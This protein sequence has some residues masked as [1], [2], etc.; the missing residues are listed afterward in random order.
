MT[1][2]HLQGGGGPP[3]IPAATFSNPAFQA[4]MAGLTPSQQAQVLFFSISL[5]TSLSHKTCFQ[6]IA[7]AQQQALLANGGRPAGQQQPN[8][9]A[10]Q[11]HQSSQQ[12]VFG[13][14]PAQQQGLGG[15]VPGQQSLEA[16]SVGQPGLGA[17]QARQPGGP[18]GLGHQFPNQLSGPYRGHIQVWLVLI[19][20]IMNLCVGHWSKPSLLQITCIFTHFQTKAP[21]QPAPFTQQSATG[22]VGPTSENRDAR[23]LQ[24]SRSAQD[25]RQQQ[26]PRQHPGDM[27]HTKPFASQPASKVLIR[28]IFSTCWQEYHDECQST[29]LFAKF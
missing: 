10:P 17:N 20:A 25:S 1:R 16:D 21:A 22:P 6:V 2:E 26:D 15:A 5:Y 23:G 13:G 7:N 11:H 4:Q 8:P 27:Q 18:T 14:L 19:N 24:D 12:Q 9:S 28:I 29:L 3:G